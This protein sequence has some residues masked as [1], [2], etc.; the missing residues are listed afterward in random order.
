MFILVTFVN[1]RNNGAVFA[2][3]QKKTENIPNR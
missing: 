1:M 3:R 2:Q